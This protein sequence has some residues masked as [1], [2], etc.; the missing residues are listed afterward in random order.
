MYTRIILDV[1]FLIYLSIC[2][3]NRITP[4]VLLAFSLIGLSLFHFSVEERASP[5]Q[6][7]R[8]RLWSVLFEDYRWHVLSADAWFTLL[9]LHDLYAFRNK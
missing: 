2:F 8:G 6:H 9:G 3:G 4:S 7:R 1:G 5:L